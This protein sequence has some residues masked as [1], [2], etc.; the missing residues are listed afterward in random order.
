[1]N[2]FIL[3]TGRSGSHTFVEACRHIT[4]YTAGHE[5][6][7]KVVGAGRVDYPENHIEVD[8]LI[9]WFLGRLDER[10]GDDAF[11]V[12]LIRSRDATARSR[13]DRMP[14]V[15][16]NV[17]FAYARGM[18]HNAQRVATPLEFSYDYYDTVEANIRLFL[19]DK[20]RQI[21]MQTE[22]A[23]EQFPAFWQAIG[24]EG[25]LDAAVREWHIT[26]NA[27]PLQ[28]KRRPELRYRIAR[29]VRKRI[30]RLLGRRP[31]SRP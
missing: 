25:D 22:D 23:A 13:V 15:P 27:G 24:A 1:M 29:K 30:L 21:T 12:H 28:M 2:V 18:Y 4:N 16:G 7:V 5:T 6:R 8:N 31:K 10:Y 19:R 26:Y 14:V 3:T 9:C 20:T 11:Y 17:M